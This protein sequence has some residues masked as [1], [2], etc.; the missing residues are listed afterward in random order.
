MN[1]EHLGRQNDEKKF[2]GPLGSYLQLNI[3]LGERIISSPS[4][5][6][7]L[8]LLLVNRHHLDVS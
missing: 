1:V 6:T 2:F 5:G 4:V 7:S 8:D 3:L